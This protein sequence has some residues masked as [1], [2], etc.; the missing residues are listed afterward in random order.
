M[1][2]G[3][4]DDLSVLEMVLAA[5]MFCFNASTPRT[6]DFRSCSCAAPQ[7][8]AQPMAMPWHHLVLINP[9]TGYVPGI[10]SVAYPQDNER[11]PELIECKRH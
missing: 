5:R 9:S 3:P 11:P 4:R 1:P 8:S 10:M 6:R 7:H 2:L